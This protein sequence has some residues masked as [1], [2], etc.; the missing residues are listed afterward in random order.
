MP[1]I[2]APDG[3]GTS[4]LAMAASAFEGVRVLPNGSLGVDHDSFGVRPDNAAGCDGE[5]FAPLRASLAGFASAQPVDRAAIRLD[6][7]GPVTL[8]VLL[9][10]AG[11]DRARAVEAARMVAILRS[12]ALF[13]AVRT[14]DAVVPVA[15]VMDEP[16]LVGS[17]HPTFPLG[18]R[19]VRSL[20]DPAV[21]ALDAVAGDS[22]V[23]IGIHVPGRADWRTIIS[24]GVSLVSMPPD[25][26][27]IGWAR[28]IQALLDNGGHI[29]WGA[30]PV[31]RPLGT[32]AELLWR[33]LSAT[34]RDLTSAGVDPDLLVRRSLVAPSD[35]LAA[36][37]PEQVPG[38][39]AVVDALAVRVQEHVAT[40]LTPV[41]A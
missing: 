24:S 5:A 2:A 39:V 22:D 31:D 15:V 32:S 6:M 33:H 38:V 40:K 20:L 18:A 26:A 3:S 28:W 30:V 36:Y 25:P 21:D 13:A 7:V 14:V 19:D 35:G 10:D 16:S 1:T 12:E 8:A 4:L 23:V 29:A 34:W 41:L 11:V 27:L 37:A 9:L 17:M